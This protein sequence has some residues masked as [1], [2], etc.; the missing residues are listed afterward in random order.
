MEVLPDEKELLLLLA[1][2]WK[3]MGP[4]GYLETSVLAERMNLS[5]E[6]TKSVVHSL[7]VKGLV[8]TDDKEHYA[9]YLTPEGY[10]FAQT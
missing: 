5:V 9:A 4:P 7:F 1:E 10:E 8:D 3:N 2:E 6:K